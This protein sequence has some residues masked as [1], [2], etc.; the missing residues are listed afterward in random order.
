MWV[1]WRTTHPRLHSL[2]DCNSI[3]DNNN[4][5]L[6][7]TSC[8][9]GTISISKTR[10]NQILFYSPNPPLFLP[11]FRSRSAN[12]I[13][14]IDA[15]PTL[16]PILQRANGKFWLN[17]NAISILHRVPLQLNWADS[18]C[19]SSWSEC[20]VPGISLHI[21]PTNF[22]N[23]CK[24]SDSCASFKYFIKLF[25]RSGWLGEYA[26]AGTMNR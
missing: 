17:V 2:V 19:L 16:L 24:S 1:L 7:S 23:R 11:F 20:R 13:S 26:V 8:R 14:T 4:S 10:L 6:W 5:N 18:G 25:L 15:L 22:S 21:C 9:G 12:I 3:Y